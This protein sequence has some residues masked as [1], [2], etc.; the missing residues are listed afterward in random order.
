MSSVRP[1]PNVFIFLSLI[2]ADKIPRF[3]F[4]RRRAYSLL[5]CWR[6]FL[7]PREI[8]PIMLPAAD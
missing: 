3:R 7:Q 4:L 5:H 8:K 2:E 6:Q 1:R